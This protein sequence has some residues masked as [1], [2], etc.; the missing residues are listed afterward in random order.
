[1][2]GHPFGR[3]LKNLHRRHLHVLLIDRH[4]LMEAQTGRGLIDVGRGHDVTARLHHIVQELGVVLVA[5]HAVLI[6]L[7]RQAIL[8]RATLSMVCIMYSI[9]SAQHRIGEKLLASFWALPHRGSAVG[10][11]MSGLGPCCSGD[12]LHHRLPSP[13]PFRNRRPAAAM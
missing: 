7:R 4:L 1:M 8:G 11:H 12:E 5:A 3:R 2:I 6:L 13:S 9:I 10:R